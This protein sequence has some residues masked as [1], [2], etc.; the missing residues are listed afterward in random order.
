[1]TELIWTDGMSVGIDAIDED[2]KQIIVILAKLTSAEH[3]ETPEQ[4]INE[5]F[6]ELEH[7]VSLHFS[8]EEALLE[9]A[10]YADIIAHKA[11]HQRFIDQLP[12]LKQEWLEKDCLACSEKIT[13]FLH[14]WLINH[15]L[16]E[17]LDYVSCVH[18]FSNSATKEK[19]KN[20]PQSSVIEK[21]ALVLSQKIKLSQRVFITT[22]LPILGVLLLSFII[23][24]D[25]Y[26]DYKNVSLVM[27]LNDVIAQVNDISHSLQAERGL[28]SGL[29]SSNYQYFNK[30]FTAQ[31]LAT[32]QSIE[33]F[34]T[35]LESGLAPAVK[36]NIRFYSAQAR[37]EFIEL[38]QYRKQ[39][40]D[41]T[42]S[43]IDTYEAY[44]HFIEQL[45]S[46]SERLTHVDMN[47]QLANDISAISALL[48]FK[49]YTG[50][51]RAL[52][53]N[54][55]LAQ[56]HDIFSNAEMSMLIGK[57]STILR[58]FHYSA[59]KEQEALCITS[60]DARIHQQLLL[61]R[62]SLVMDE[63][64]IEQRSQNW[65]NLMSAEIDK[66]KMLTDELTANFKEKVQGEN[67]RLEN[68]Y[69]GA[70]LLLSLFLISA[71]LFSLILN[72]SIINPIRQVTEALNKM[73][74]GYG[75]MQFKK[76]VTADEIGAM[77]SA[78][79]KLRRKL[80]QV[81]I[82]QAIVDRQQNEIEYRKSQQAHLKTLACT[83]ALTG[84]VNRHHFNKVLAD[85]IAQ[86][87]YDQLPLSI[88]L[89]DIDYFKQVNDSFG[90][91]VGDEVLIMF[92]RA[93]KV[94]V[95]SND[96][97]ARIGGEE[98]VI[99][100]PKTNEKNAYQFAERLRDK[101]QQLEIIVDDNRID[102]TVS[103]GVSQWN[104]DSC[105][106]A[107]EFVANADRLLYQAKHRGRNTVVV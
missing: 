29:I 91:A 99:I 28:A 43:F 54:M 58:V 74:Q 68:S 88:M 92:Y 83:D 107:E 1:M 72:H 63:Q 81:D 12:V 70:L 57:Q 56:E 102:L 33:K 6:V 86:A 42:V 19:N 13:T 95:R 21:M 97:V 52:G 103:I 94:A 31:S 14:Q 25:N 60:C 32:D 3:G 101:I 59:S 4:T 34:L 23:L 89:L 82:F 80:L 37:G 87:D 44:M 26:K 62:F 20:Q 38:K 15:I 9:K 106:S 47:S 64:D 105:S 71:T 49:E 69:Y 53:M 5:I 7:Y 65:F 11:S 85:E 8:R 96:V 104:K 18:E 16:V 77:Q 40:A 30:Q 41:R 48:L 79:E 55:V 46:I 84:A 2:H 73:A 50:Q 75:N 27:G 36:D 76:A 61:Q 39:L 17:D 45:L 24:F 22:L 93:C 10:C 90:H 78:Y 100:L 51:V 66:L 98:F 35:L 67:Q